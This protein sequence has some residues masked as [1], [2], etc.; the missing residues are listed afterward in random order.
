MAIEKPLYLR[1]MTQYYINVISY[2]TFCQSYVSLMN[3]KTKIFLIDKMC[4]KQLIA[5]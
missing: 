1:K 4:S 3:I 5:L 2:T